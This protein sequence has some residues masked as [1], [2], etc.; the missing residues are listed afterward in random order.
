M[1]SI[2]QN[3][4]ALDA[5]K[6]V[7]GSVLLEN[8]VMDEI[9]TMLEPRDFTIHSHELVWKAMTYMHSNYQPIDPVTLTDMLSKYKRLDEMGG[10]SYLIELASVVPSSANAK[11]YANIVRKW[12]VRRRTA[13]IGE[14]ISQFAWDEGLEEEQLFTNIEQ[15]ADSIRPQNQGGLVHIRETRQGYFDYLDQ[16]DDHIF[17][18]LK[19]FDEWMGGVGRGW[20]YVLAARPSV[21]KTAKM[22]QMLKGIA[23]QGQGQC[24]LW[25]QEMKKYALYNRMLANMTGIS[26]NKFRLKKLNSAEKEL[27]RKAFDQLEQLPIHMEDAR[28]V[29]I[30]EV[31]SV[32]RQ[33][34]RKYGP[35][36]AIFIDYLQ[37]MDIP[38]PLGWTRTQA[39]G[40]V[41]RKAKHT[42]N[43]LDCPIILLCQMSREGAKAM[44]PSLEHLRES[45]NIEQDADVVE[46]LW[47]NPE[48]SDPGSQHVGAR[49]VQSIIAKGRDVGV[50]EFRL[51]FKTW[52]QKFEEI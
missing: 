18:G 25:S 48:D 51:A 8:Q 45:G 33:M 34:K 14:K 4:Q 29:T 37:I 10:V 35:I 23:S 38:Q 21:G 31:R 43:E 42:A 15:L 3:Q 6:A 39:I 5:E 26:A 17:T 28:N 46:F 1:N 9:S 41:T 2:L 50:N 16:M 44:K 40:E 47:E 30:E 32:A 7:L 20:I 19:R 36:S 24:L 49:V 12:A 22:L 27:A 52:T 13:E 11:Y